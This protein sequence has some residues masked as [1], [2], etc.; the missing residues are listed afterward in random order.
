MGLMNVKQKGALIP[1]ALIPNSIY[2]REA[3]SICK[4]KGVALFIAFIALI[5]TLKAAK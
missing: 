3:C 2:P 4:L 5:R 1:I